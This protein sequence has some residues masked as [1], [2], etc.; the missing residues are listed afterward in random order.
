MEKISNE[1]RCEKARKRYLIAGQLLEILNKDEDP[2]GLYR[3]REF[4]RLLPD[5]IVDGDDNISDLAWY[6]IYSLLINRMR[7]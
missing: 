4:Q 1:K 7:P 5:N 6:N 3:S 2:H